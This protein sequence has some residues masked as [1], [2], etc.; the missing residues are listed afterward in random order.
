[1]NILR[2]RI[3]A[4]FLICLHWLLFAAAS[5]CMG[6]AITVAIQWI[7]GGTLPGIWNWASKYPA[8]L[9]MTTLLYA[10]AVAILGAL[11]GRLWISG[12]LVGLAGLLLALVDYFKIAIN[13]SPLEL[14]D[15]GMAGRIGAIAKVAGELIPPL[16]FWL[17]AVML[18]LCVTLLALTRRLTMLNGQIRFLTFSLYV[19][20]AVMLSVPSSARAF[21][22]RLGMDFNV[23]LDP[24]TNH[25]HH[26]LTLS[27][28]RDCFLQSKP[29]AEGYG[30]EYMQ[31]VL[32]RVDEL[33]LENGTSDISETSPNI[34]FILSE[35][36]FDPTRLPGVIYGQDPVEN[37]H[38]LEKEGISGILHSHHLGYGTGNI[39][40]SMLTGIRSTDLL[41][42]T[43][44]CAMY[45]EVYE[46]FDSL[47]EQYTKVDGYHAEMAHAYNDELYNRTINYPLFGFESLLFFKDIKALDIDWEK[48]LPDTYYMQDSY[49]CKALLNRLESI[50]AEGRRAFLYGISMENHQPYTPEKFNNNCQTTV[51]ADILSPEE[52]DVFRSM[53]EGIIRADQALGELTTAL[54]DFQ[55]PTILVFFG[56]HR[57]NLTLPDGETAYTK[58]GLCPGKWTYN[59]VPEQFN[60]LYSTDYLIWAN[61]AALLQGQ[62]GIR[63]DSSVTAIGPHL[64]ELTGRHVSRYWG[65]ME[66]CAEICL[67]HTSFYFVDGEGN[68]SVSPEEAGLSPEAVELLKLREAVIYDAVYG[69]QYITDE[70]N[71]PAGA[72]LPAESEETEKRAS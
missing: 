19:L 24:A 36:F 5:L 12:A 30:K 45:S 47:A 9:L 59:W 57:P 29:P 37:F 58:L 61:D 6:L 65:L 64:L 31:D 50:H 4:I 28:W 38:S 34:I 26:G 20:L 60:E 15:F 21:G 35:S 2:K 13:G 25:E 1:M 44:M 7:T 41:P 46:R 22:G 17:S 27:L 33:L 55:E 18:V 68:P 39:E 14:A 32:A 71:L 3:Y 67:T 62:T 70:M 51:T 40:I 42:G 52:L 8:N 16:D 54:R 11:I 49:F 69:K 48:R 72:P 53:L 43:D 56:D 66:K 63:R 10:L 23:R